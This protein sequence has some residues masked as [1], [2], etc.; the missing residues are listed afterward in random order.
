MQDQDIIALYFARNEAAITETAAKYGPYC[1][2][3]ARNIVPAPEDAEECVNDT[4][5]A[6]WNSMPPK[7]P[8]ILRLFLAKITRS[9]AINRWKAQHAKKRGSDEVTLVLDEL[10]ECVA[11]GSDPEKEVLAAELSESIDAFLRTQ[12]ERERSL[13]IRRYFFTEA[14]DKIAQDYGMTAGNV[15][16][17]LH[18]TRKK[19]AEHLTKEGYL[20]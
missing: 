4:Y 8:D 7:K 17:T 16:V 9:R 14:V 2:T 1:Y 5:L 13:F 15:S 20:S 12:P 18:R 6:A 10:E 3:V 19:L 11:G